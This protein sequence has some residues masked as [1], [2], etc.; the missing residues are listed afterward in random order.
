MSDLN[1]RKLYNYEF[2]CHEYRTGHKVLYTLKA[3]SLVEAVEIF[4]NGVQYLGALFVKSVRCIDWPEQ[5]A[6]YE[7]DT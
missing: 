2:E 3:S 4:Y 1:K 5:V 6:E 7:R